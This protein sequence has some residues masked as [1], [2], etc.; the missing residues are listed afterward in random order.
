[1]TLWTNPL[2]QR[3]PTDARQRRTKTRFESHSKPAERL[4]PPGS[5]T[6]PKA[7]LAFRLLSSNP[8]GPDLPTL[9]RAPARTGGMDVPP[10]P[11]RS[12]ADA[13]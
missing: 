6:D 3:L 7:N 8:H 1:M 4:H 9:W 2:V 5:E 13:L 12:D 10:L 11:F